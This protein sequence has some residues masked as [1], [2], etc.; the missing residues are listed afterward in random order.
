TKIQRVREQQLLSEE[1]VANCL[2]ISVEEYRKIE[3]KGFK[4]LKQNVQNKICL[5]FGVAAKDLTESKERNINLSSLGFAR[6]SAP[7]SEK[8]EQ[9]IRKLLNLKKIYVEEIY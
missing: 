3:K 9:E 2:S 6:N 4:Q 1:F 8:D 5:L 7:F